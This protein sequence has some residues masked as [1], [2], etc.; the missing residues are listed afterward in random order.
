MPLD[1]FAVGDDTSSNRGSVVASPSNEHHTDRTDMFFCLEDV[2]LF[3]RLN[4]CTPV[5]SDNDDGLRVLK[6]SFDIGVRMSHVGGADFEPL[7]EDHDEGGEVK[8]G[9]GSAGGSGE[10]IWEAC[11]APAA[12]SGILYGVPCIGALVSD[13]MKR[14]YHDSEADFR[15]GS[16]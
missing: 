6:V 16:Q 13:D 15:C 10:I 11:A 4:F 1:V 9:A 2:G 7:D 14:S 5:R 12:A 8:N 3:K